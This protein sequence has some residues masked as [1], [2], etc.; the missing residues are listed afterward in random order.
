VTR[1]VASVAC[2][3]LL[4]ACRVPAGQGAATSSGTSVPEASISS[5]M[6]SPRACR[7][8]PAWLVSRLEAALTP[9][10]SG[11]TRIFVQRATN[12]TGSD[13]VSG[14][15]APWWVAALINGA[16]VRPA[17]ASWLVERLDES[18]SPRIWSADVNA[19]RYSKHRSGND[20]DGGGLSAVRSCVGPAPPS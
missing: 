6:E 17:A 10:G 14:L 8:A 11:L 3:A 19:R 20:L 16:G 2:V 18:S 4:A 1:F 7:A 5:P 12:V 9:P 13:E 15:P